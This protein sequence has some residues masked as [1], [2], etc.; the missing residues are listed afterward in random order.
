MIA[1]TLYMCDYMLALPSCRPFNNSSCES[2]MSVVETC[3]CAEPAL[4]SFRSARRR[5]MSLDCIETYDWLNTQQGCRNTLQHTCSESS[6]CTVRHSR[7]CLPPLER[8]LMEVHIYKIKK[9]VS[10]MPA[11]VANARDCLG[12]TIILW[13]R[14]TVLPQQLQHQRA[15]PDSA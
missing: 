1:C 11:V 14:H 5:M 6:A 9:Q 7:C 2:N 15:A 13:C 4:R 12:S 8:L 3:A 10:R